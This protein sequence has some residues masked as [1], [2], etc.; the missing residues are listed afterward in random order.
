VGGN[1][2][3]HGAER[4]PERY[5]F[6]DA[7]VSPSDPFP[8]AG[9]TRVIRSFKGALLSSYIRRSACLGFLNV[10]SIVRRS[11]PR[12]QCTREFDTIIAEPYR[13][14]QYLFAT[15]NPLR[16]RSITNAANSAT[17]T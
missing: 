15:S 12:P 4:I 10:L 3:S 8:E 6:L 16:N 9:A 1:V 2:F 5:I 11:P 17:R 7:D 14:R 13:H